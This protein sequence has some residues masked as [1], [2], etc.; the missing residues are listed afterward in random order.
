MASR[1]LVLWT[2]YLVGTVQLSVVPQPQDDFVPGAAP[3]AQPQDGVRAPK[4]ID[5]NV[6]GAPFFFINEGELRCFYEELNANLHVAVHY[7]CPHLDVGQ[8]AKELDVTAASLTPLGIEVYVNDPVGYPVWLPVSHQ[9]LTSPDET[10]AFDSQEAG[11]Y[12]ICLR[13]N[14]SHY[15][16]GER[17][18]LHLQ[19][20]IG[21][22]AI[23]W[24]A[25]AAKDH[26][27]DLHM[28]VEKMKAAIK[29]IRDDQAVLIE[30]DDRFQKTSA[31]TYTRVWAMAL[32]QV[33]LLCA[34]AMW[35]MTSFKKF[36]IA[37]KLV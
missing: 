33:G 15:H 22:D 12:E 11:E 31:S 18:K 2:L 9:V 23:D 3:T 17:V 6:H 25:V 36:L 16:P 8:R 26:L 27:D 35:Q 19:I 1:L 29:D 7:T 21:A 24:K 5:R 34:T 30:R 37:K 14:S 10:F 32:V 20:V 4:V 13:T 28:R